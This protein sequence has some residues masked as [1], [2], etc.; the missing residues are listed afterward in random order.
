MGSHSGGELS[1]SFI[2]SNKFEYV[3]L[4]SDGILTEQAGRQESSEALRSRMMVISN[5]GFH[6]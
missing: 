3:I 4:L 1:V 2:S 5:V 6:R